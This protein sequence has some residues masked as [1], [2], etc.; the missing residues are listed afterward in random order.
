MQSY[1]VKLAWCRSNV[2]DALQEYRE[3]MDQYYK[4]I[5]V[6]RGG[7]YGASGARSL[8][9]L[10]W[11]PMI[12]YAHVENVSSANGP[13]VQA[14]CLAAYRVAVEYFDLMKPDA[15]AL[16]TVLQFNALFEL[17]YGAGDPLDVRRIER[18]P[19]EFLALV[20]PAAVRHYRAPASAS[21]V[22][23][24]VIDLAFE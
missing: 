13:V 21:S 7:T 9:V 19:Q 8:R 14:C 6:G 2:Q 11:K 1:A 18:S 5:P 24:D 3:L 17:S 10:Q 4:P 22:F 15:T 23:D 20:F 16:A 12:D